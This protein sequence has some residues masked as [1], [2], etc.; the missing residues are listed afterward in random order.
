MSS[1]LTELAKHCEHYL[2]AEDYANYNNNIEIFNQLGGDAL[3]FPSFW[4][5]AC[6]FALYGIISKLEDPKYP[7]QS[8]EEFYLK[9]NE[10]NN[11]FYHDGSNRDNDNI[12]CDKLRL[13]K[14]I[15][16][17]AFLCSV[18][19]ETLKSKSVTAFDEPSFD[20]APFKGSD[21]SEYTDHIQA[22]AE[23]YNI[24]NLVVDKF[25]KI[26]TGNKYDKAKIA[27]LIR[28][29]GIT[30]VRMPLLQIVDEIRLLLPDPLSKPTLLH[31][32]LKNNL[33]A[34]GMN[35]NKK[36]VHEQILT[37]NADWTEDDLHAINMGDNSAVLYNLNRK[38]NK[39]MLVGPRSS[40]QVLSPVLA[41]MDHESL[42]HR[43]A[44]RLDHVSQGIIA[45]RGQFAPT[46][47]ANVTR[48]HVR[49]D[50]AALIDEPGAPT[51]LNQKAPKR[52]KN[53]QYVEKVLNARLEELGEGRKRKAW[54]D[55]EVNALL[56]GIRKHYD[57]ARRLGQPHDAK[58]ANLWSEIKKDPDFEHELRL[59]TNVM[60]KDKFRTLYSQN[61]G[62]FPEDMIP[63]A[64]RSNRN[65]NNNNTVNQ[66]VTHEHNIDIGNNNNSDTDEEDDHMAAKKRRGPR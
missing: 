49:D 4:K 46:V 66:Q 45:N 27:K 55:Y 21:H 54:T 22:L 29:N 65:N 57:K 30:T 32:P 56:S 61:P 31:Q 53:N 62:L 58:N 17:N 63:P 9:Y 51:N 13:V 20:V 34:M 47:Q 7:N 59:R 52:K 25:Q 24:D 64:D 48:H 60:C 8:Y 35:P 37:Q 2:R 40:A 26:V 28:E 3:K 6:R 16:D 14:E 11:L 33:V 50:E 44:Q 42:I 12:I 23:Q 39:N 19:F 10:L 15:L 41:N 43:G 1:Q 38:D 5:Q 18:M 36:K